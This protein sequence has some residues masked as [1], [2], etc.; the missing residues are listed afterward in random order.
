MY[1]HTL[2]LTQSRLSYSYTIMVTITLNTALFQ[3]KFSSISKTCILMSCADLPPLRL[4][5]LLYILVLLTQYSFMWQQQR[6]AQRQSANALGREK[7]YVQT[8]MNDLN[9]FDAI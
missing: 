9:E 3:G 4:R 6:D 2:R 5:I 8:G 1:L 7:M